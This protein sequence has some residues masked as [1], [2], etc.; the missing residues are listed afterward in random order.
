[1]EAILIQPKNKTE[2]LF[3]SEMFKKL[4]IK[5]KVILEEEK[6][7]YF[8]SK[9]IEEGMKTKTVSKAKILNALR[10]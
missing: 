5:T 8:L 3:L 2:F 4:N 10:K 6:E 7:N 9:A 1:M